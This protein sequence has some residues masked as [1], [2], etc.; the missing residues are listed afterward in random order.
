[1]TLAELAQLY[2]VHPNQT[3][4]WQAQ[5][6][7]RTAGVRGADSANDSDAMRVPTA[8][9]GAWAC[10]NKMPDRKDILP[11]ILYLRRVERWPNKLEH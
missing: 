1:M 11:F 4:T 5:L 7:E 2:D 10:V 6:L 8:A 3:T 9:R